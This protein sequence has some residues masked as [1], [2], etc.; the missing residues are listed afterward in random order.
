YEVTIAVRATKSTEDAVTNGSETGR[1]GARKPERPPEPTA[2]VL[3]YHRVA[4]VSAD[5]FSLCV[6][7]ERFSEHMDTL[8]KVAQPLRLQ[9]LAHHLRSGTLPRRSVV[10]TFDD[11]YVDNLQ[12]AKPLLERFDIPAT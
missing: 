10:V 2:L 8:R 6:A 11:G 5:P 3:M 12:K 4:E 1:G 7:P 9:Q